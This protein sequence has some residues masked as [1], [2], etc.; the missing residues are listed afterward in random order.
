M[1]TYRLQAGGIFQ[2]VDFLWGRQLN[3]INNSIIALLKN[4]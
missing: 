4:F 2:C 3:D 1:A